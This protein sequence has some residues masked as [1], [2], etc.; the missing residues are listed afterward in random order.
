MKTSKGPFAP[1]RKLEHD[2]A[3]A[4]TFWEGLKRREAEI[5]FWDDVNL[6]V[7]PELSDRLAMIDATDK[8]VRFRFGFGVVGAEIKQEYGADPAGKFLDEIEAAA[9]AAI[10]AFLNA[11]P[12][13]KAARSPITSTPGQTAAVRAR[14]RDIRVLYC[15]CGETAASACCWWRLPGN[16]RRKAALGIADRIERR[17]T[18]ARLSMADIVTLTINPSIDLSVSVERIEPFHKLRCAD[19]RRD[20]G[21]GGINA[22][23]VMKRLGADV[24]AFYPIGGSARTIAAPPGRSGRHSGIDHSGRRGNARGLYGHRAR[25]RL[26]IPL[27]AAR[28]ASHRNGMERLP[29]T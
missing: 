5:P 14:S 6:S 18:K 1:P 28:T 2:L 29:R 26:S 3:R 7:L 23:R 24:T 15:R 10:P 13:S 21:G 17:C 4:L 8:P 27:R 25:H 12:R 16:R 9:S 20:P 11:A 22:A 19:G